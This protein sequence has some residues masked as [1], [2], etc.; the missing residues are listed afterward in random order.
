MCAAP[1][2]WLLILWSRHHER[3]LMWCS[4]VLDKVA[5]YSSN[6]IQ[7]KAG[8]DD[9]AFVADL[10]AGA[11]GYAEVVVAAAVDVVVVVS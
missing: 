8:E 10:A 9:F 11:V 3:A 7:P 5:K 1:L 6:D 2:M 4:V